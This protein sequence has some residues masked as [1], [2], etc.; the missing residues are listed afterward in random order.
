MED[1]DKDFGEKFEGTVKMLHRKEV[2]KRGIKRYVEEVG[3][4]FD[5]KRRKG[6]VIYDQGG[7]LQFD[8][9]ITDPELMEKYKPQADARVFV[10]AQ[11]FSR[12][13]LMRFPSEDTITAIDAQEFLDSLDY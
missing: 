4:P 6:R 8:F 10:F 9:G 13:W 1:A 2:L 5:G 11:G 12:K 3:I 7:N